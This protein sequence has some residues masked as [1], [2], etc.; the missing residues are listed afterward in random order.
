MAPKAIVFNISRYKPGVIDPPRFQAYTLRVTEELTVLDGLEKIR[1]EQEAGLM[2]RHSCHHSAC[3]TCACV[4]NGSEKLACITRILA[5]GTDTVT[6]E[7]LAGFR[8]LGDLVVDMAPFYAHIGADWTHIRP[9][10]P[11]TKTADG[12]ATRRFTR[13]ENCIE[14]GCCISA[15]P[16][17]QENG[18]FMGP[19]ALSALHRESL[20]VPDKAYALGRLA[21]KKEG[22]PLCARALACSRVCPTAVYPAWHITELRKKE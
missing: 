21:D 19:A 9:A 7:P 17:S 20:N 1:Q 8:R 11:L 22:A 15:C 12:T 2:Y 14:C 5:L 13:F 16:V 18:T 3:G 4:V 6:L 10:E